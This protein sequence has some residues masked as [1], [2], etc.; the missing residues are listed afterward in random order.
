MA[1]GKKAFELIDWNKPVSMKERLLADEYVLPEGWQ[2]AVKGVKELVFFNSGAL[3]DD[4]A[5]AIGMALFEKK[6]GIKMRCIE[7]G[8]AYTF[9]KLLSVFTSKDPNI[10]F[11]FVRAEIEYTQVAAAGWAHPIN[12]LW[13]AEVSDIYPVGPDGLHRV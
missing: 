5:T 8:S 12:E 4:I 10:H 9:P 13:P 7:V 1:A 11:G 3:K 2:E 6:T